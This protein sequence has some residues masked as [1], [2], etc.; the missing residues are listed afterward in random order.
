ML[1]ESYILVGKL[2]NYGTEK[3]KFIDHMNR[4]NNE[5]VIKTLIVFGYLMKKFDMLDFVSD[6][7]RVPGI[8]NEFVD[9]VFEPHTFRDL[10][11]NH[12]KYADNKLI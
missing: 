6:E 1:F 4:F 11:K 10:L 8:T 5:S 2:L 7:T 3:D 12:D 9:R